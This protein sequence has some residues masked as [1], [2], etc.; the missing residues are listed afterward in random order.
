MQERVVPLEGAVTYRMGR[1]PAGEIFVGDVNISE[2]VATEFRDEINQA[3]RCLNR[4]KPIPLGEYRVV[5][6]FVPVQPRSWSR[7]SEKP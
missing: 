7:Q 3:M 4:L 6:R 2:A 1:T 5:V